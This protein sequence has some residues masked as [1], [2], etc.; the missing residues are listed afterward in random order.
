MKAPKL[1]IVKQYINGLAAQLIQ[2]EN[3]DIMNSILTVLIVPRPNSTSSLEISVLDVIEESTTVGASDTK[4]VTD[5]TR[6]VKIVCLW[7]PETF[8]TKNNI[9]IVVITTQTMGINV[10]HMVMNIEIKRWYLCTKEK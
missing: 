3:E 10:K 5:T 8:F 9:Q 7:I 6:S 4:N 1:L 2:I